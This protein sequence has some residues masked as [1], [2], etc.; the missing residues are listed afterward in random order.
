[1]DIQKKRKRIRGIENLKSWYGRAFVVPWSFGLVVFFVVPLIQSVI[2]V[3]SDV[4]L[5]TEGMKKAFTGLDNIKYALFE[6]P[7][8]TNNLMK[9]LGSFL[10]TFPMIMIISLV[11][12]IILVQKF[13]GRLFFRSLYFLPVIIASGVVLEHI[14]SLQTEGFSRG[15]TDVSL[16]ES[17][18]NAED[19]IAFFGLPGQIKNYF[20]AVMEN[21]L[22]LMWNS[23][24]QIIL[25]I[26]GLQAIPDQLY[27]VSKVEGATKWEEFWFVTFPMLSRVVVLVFAFTAVEFFTSKT[28]LVMSQAYNMMQSQEYGQSS[29]MLWVYL[30]SMGVV[31]GIVFMLYNRLY[32]C[33]KSE[34]L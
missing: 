17:M 20:Q 2:Y 3:F 4:T 33:R 31:A 18:I 10:Y 6:D 23:G 19:I 7:T 24:I 16:L 11:L 34:G 25:F 14:F 32:A 26:A 30:L 9:S 29:A 13:K 22:N 1:M 15:G 21:I 8:F 5:S 28:D 12:A 27:E